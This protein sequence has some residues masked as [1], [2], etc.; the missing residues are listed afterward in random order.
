MS[1]ASI[2]TPSTNESEIKEY[3]NIE[4]YNKNYLL[5]AKIKDE[6]IDFI[7]SDSEEGNI[8][9]SRKMTLNEIHQNKKHFFF[10]DLSS[11]NEF[12]DYLKSLSQ[13]K[14]LSIIKKEG[15]ISI[16]FAVECLLKKYPIEIDLYPEKSNSKLI[17]INL[18]QELYLIKDRIKNLENQN[19]I[20][21]KENIKRRKYKIKRRN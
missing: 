3:L 18:Y 4:Q 11:C 19:N 21:I 8:S 20:I 14:K 1:E 7:L 15:K 2:I 6:T 16:N 9:Y 10:Q 17:D 13:E 12:F 5:F